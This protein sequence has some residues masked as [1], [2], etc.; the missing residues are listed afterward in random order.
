MIF[1]KSRNKP[2][3]V[4]KYVGFSMARWRSRHPHPVGTM[5]AQSQ[6]DHRANRP[7]PRKN[8]G[9]ETF[10]KCK[11]KPIRGGLRYSTTGARGRPPALTRFAARRGVPQIDLSQFAR[12]D[13]VARAG[14]EN[15]K[16]KPI[17]PNPR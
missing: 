12:G 10:Q 9:E 11:N 2:I 13:F 16:N 15:C 17:T 8:V 6:S 7:L 1:E 3:I 4:S 5:V 14:E